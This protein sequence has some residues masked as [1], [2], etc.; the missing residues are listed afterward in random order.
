LAAIWIPPKATDAGANAFRLYLNYN[1]AGSHFGDTSVAATTADRDKI[2]VYAAERS[3]DHAI[4]IVVINKTGEDLDAPISIA[5]APAADTADVWRYSAKASRIVSA[6]PVP[7]SRGSIAAKVPAQSMSLYVVP[8][9]GVAN[10]EPAATAATTAPAATPSSSTASASS[11]SA[12]KPG[13]N[14]VLLGLGALLAVAAGVT[15]VLRADLRNA[16]RG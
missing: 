7:V 5:G 16:R 11:P 3:S 2:A 14:R 9:K 8:G 12:G 6:A 10:S 1:G 4:T 13:P 15:L